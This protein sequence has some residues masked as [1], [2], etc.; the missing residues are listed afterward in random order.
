MSTLPRIRPVLGLMVLA[1][2]VAG[3]AAANKTWYKPDMTE[4]QW[5]VDSATCKSRAQRLAEDDYARRSR[6]PVG[7]TDGM[8]GYNALMDSH[9][10]GR[11][12]EGLYRDCL[13]RKGYR[14]ISPG[15]VP[16]AGAKA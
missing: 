12:A 1:V 10:V 11:S 6:A 13:R 9:R 4:D 14:L 2:T 16:K 15:Q 7:A 5:A 8:A 3:C